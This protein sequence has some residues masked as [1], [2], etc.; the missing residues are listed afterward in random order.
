[1]EKPSSINN[2]HK[3]KNIPVAGT[4]HRSLPP[5]AQPPLSAWVPFSSPESAASY[6]SPAPFP[7]RAEGNTV[8]FVFKQVLQPP[9]INTEHKNKKNRRM[10]ASEILTIYKRGGEPLLP[11]RSLTFNSPA[12]G[13]N[14]HRISHPRDNFMPT[15][16]HSFKWIFNRLIMTLDHDKLSCWS[17]IGLSL[18]LPIDILMNLLLVLRP[19]HLFCCLLCSPPLRGLSS[20]VLCLL[21]PNIK[22]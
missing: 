19:P 18:Y 7:L 16:I 5:Q 11:S 17:M 15:S 3:R 4:P 20:W 6:A 21:L 9:I 14:A 8:T 12:S 1:M 10:K 2:H 22:K 13:T